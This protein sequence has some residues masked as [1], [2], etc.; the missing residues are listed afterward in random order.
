MRIP[1]LA[2]V[3]AFMA[4]PRPDTVAQPRA[5]IGAVR[6][7]ADALDL[8][9]QQLSGEIDYAGFCA[10]MRDIERDHPGHPS[11]GLIEAARLN[12]RG[13]DDLLRQALSQ[14][15]RAAGRRP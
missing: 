9:V 7:L 15:R 3:G 4:R 6:A 13:H 2:D 1:S 10:C 14:A 11:L 8:V 5:E 12:P